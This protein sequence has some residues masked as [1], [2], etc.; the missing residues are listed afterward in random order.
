VVEVSLMIRNPWFTLIL[1]LM[2]GIAVGYILGE[3]QAVPPAPSLPPATQGGALPDGHPPVD[4]AAQAANQRLQQ[5]VSEIQGL[6]NTSP[7]DPGL[8]AAMGNAFFDAQQWEDARVWYERSLQAAP[9]DPNVLTDLAVVYRNL[10]ESERAV[11]L[12]D[13]VLAGHPE[14]WQALYNKVVILQFDLHQHDEAGAALRSLQELKKSNPSIPD[15]S[16]LEKEVLG[17]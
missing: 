11:Q 3:R 13:E 14:H 1:G 9:G 12:L 6:L 15:L 2:V 10:K 16:G 8:M 4:E 5:Q 17:S 7:D